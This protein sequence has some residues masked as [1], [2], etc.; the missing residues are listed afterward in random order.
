MV[1]IVSGSLPEPETY[2]AFDAVTLTFWPMLSHG[3][4]AFTGA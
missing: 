4:P 3:V 2:P 1:Y